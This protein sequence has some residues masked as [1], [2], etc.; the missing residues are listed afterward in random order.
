MI[1][2]EHPPVS[3]RVAELHRTCGDRVS[4]EVVLLA[5]DGLQL[6]ALLAV[7]LLAD[8]DLDLCWE[9]QEPGVEVAADQMAAGVGDARWRLGGVVALMLAEQDHLGAMIL[10]AQK[11]RLVRR[12]EWSPVVGV[13]VWPA[14]GFESPAAVGVSLEAPSEPCPWCHE[15]YS[16]SVGV[17]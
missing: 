7:V 17:A 13:A 12:G 11:P 14:L 8:E 2:V 5:V 9:A 4:L 15:R 3:E 1:V 16:E 6:S 10:A